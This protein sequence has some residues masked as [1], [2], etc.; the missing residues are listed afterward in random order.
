MNFHKGWK[1]RK[2][3]SLFVLFFLI[4]SATAIT[5]GEKIKVGENKWVEGAYAKYQLTYTT[6]NKTDKPHTE[7]KTGE[8]EFHVLDKRVEVT[9]HV[10]PKLFK[11]VKF[12]LKNGSIYY[13]GKHVVLPFFYRGEKTVAFY[14]NEYEN[15]TRM[16]KSSAS[17][18]SGIVHGRPTLYTTTEVIRCINGT[19]TNLGSNSYIFGATTGLLFH[20]IVGYSILLNRLFNLSVEF[21]DFAISDTNIELGREN[22]GALLTYYL[23]ITC[24]VIVIIAIFV[25]FAYLYRRNYRR[26][27]NAGYSNKRPGKK[28]R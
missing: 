1:L 20:G 7:E 18:R 17:L 25:I 9:I 10:P 4:F 27:Y 13:H 16:I 15:I 5:R 8:L 3:S 19:V 6:I 21:A 28:V 24:P 26:H 14:D 22:K 11:S 23:Y 12:E 2:I